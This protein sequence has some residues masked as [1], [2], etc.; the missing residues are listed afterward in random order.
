MCPDAP[1]H[2]LNTGDLPEAASSNLEGVRVLIVEDS[3]QVATAIKDLICSWG[4]DAVGPVATTADALHLIFECTPDVALVDIRL[5]N[6][7]LSYGL[8]DRLHE[9]GVRVVVTSGYANIQVAPEKIAANLEKPIDDSRLLAILQEIATA[10][11]S[12]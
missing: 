10:K 6:G 11:A 8:I 9:Q 3:W 4:A 5:R 2:S 1:P 12:R 7:E